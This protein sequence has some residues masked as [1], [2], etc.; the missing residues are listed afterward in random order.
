MDLSYFKQKRGLLR[1]IVSMPLF[2]RSSPDL[3][4]ASIG[5]NVLSLALPI[6]LMQVYDRIVPNKAV[7]TLLWLVIG[8][9]GALI[10][11]SILRICRSTIVNWISAR[12]EHSLAHACVSR[13]LT[14]NLEEFERDGAGV[15]LDRLRAVSALKSFYA[16]QAFQL[17]M[18]LP[19]A[20]LFLGVIGFLGGRMVAAY[21][22]GMAILYLIIISFIR[23]RYSK[24]RIRQKT[25]GDRRYNFLVEAL[26][27]I[28]T[29]KSI[30]LEES[31][32]RRHERLKADGAKADYDV[33]FVGNLPV[34]LGNMF[35]QFIL[36]GVLFFGGS[37]AISGQ[38]TLGS[39]AACTLLS[40]R[41]FSPFKSLASFWVRHADIKIAKEQI[42]GIADLGEEYDPT[43]PCLASEIAGVIQMKKVSFRYDE[44]SPYVLK[45]LN[46]HVSKG[47]MVCLNTQ[48]SRGTT[49]LLNLIYGMLKPTEGEVY[50]DDANIQDI[51]HNDYKGRMEFIPQNGTL[52]NG[53]I[54]ENLTLF[55]PAH[56]DAALDAASL[57][58]LDTILS[59]LPHGYET[60]VGNR[61]YEFLPSGVIQRICLARSLAIRPRIMLMDRASYAMDAESEEHFYWLLDKLK[62]QCTMVIATSDPV[63]LAKADTVYT[64]ADGRLTEQEAEQCF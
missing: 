41:F 20:L 5:I 3:L 24:D 18:D 31:M 7:S 12:F 32:L 64:I 57:L 21:A 62:G 8:F 44:K 34:S 54:F 25:I 40:G 30:T 56:R 23:A 55:N 35:S 53:T 11:D 45:D 50:I 47:R 58:G 9:F 61:L 2:L 1:D 22:G 19:F 14:S 27:G 60:H 63:I 15:H 52:F 6:I 39:L 42:K 29:I 48:G 59:D 33:I 38:M 46:L 51:C 37:Q 36:F 17:I 4:L 26:S 49:T 10:L 28:H 43:A 16:G 13:W